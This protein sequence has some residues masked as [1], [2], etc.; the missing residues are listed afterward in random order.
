LSQYAYETD[1]LQWQT[2][3]TNFSY[4]NDV[5]W[6]NNFR[7]GEYLRLKWIILLTQ[8]SDSSRGLYIEMDK[9]W[10]LHIH[11]TCV[12]LGFVR[13]IHWISGQSSAAYGTA[14]QIWLGLLVG[15]SHSYKHYTFVILNLLIVTFLKW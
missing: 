2:L 3:N 14:S 9:G 7:F 11:K 6:L 1:L 4:I 13:T 8:R 5:M 10:C 12:I 15:W